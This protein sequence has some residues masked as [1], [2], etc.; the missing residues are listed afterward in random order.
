MITP[1]EFAQL[2]PLAVAWVEQ[3]EN[4]IL[5]NGV[6]LAL[7]QLADARLVSVVN[8]EKV[9]LLKVNQI[10]LPSELSLKRAAQ[11]LS[12]ITTNTTGLTLR[13]GVFIREDFW[14]DR[15][16]VVHELVHVAQYERLGGIDQFLQKYLQECITNGY[17]QAPMEQEARILV[18]KI[19]VASNF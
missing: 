5:E 16:I 18:N 2:F 14:N 19:V 13:Y 9:R 7:F 4:Y 3:Q 11:T 12:L 6:Q 17:P 8:P 10:P 15:K 1:Q